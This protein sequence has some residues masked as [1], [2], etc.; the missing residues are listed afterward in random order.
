M[1]S[2]EVRT[3]FHPRAVPVARQKQQVKTHTTADTA[4]R[5][6][7]L[8]TL[9]YSTGRTTARQRSAHMQASS[10]GQPTRLSMLNT[11]LVR[12]RGCFGV[13]TQR[14]S[15]RRMTDIRSTWEADSD[16]LSL[17]NSQS[18]ATLATPPVTRMKASMASHMVSHRA[19][20][21]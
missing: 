10:R 7:H 5:Y 20:P 21:H 2:C 14:A 11:S 3:E 15:G 1:L 12:S 13:V 6:S 9:R 8:L 18:R 16:F 4:I 17:R 19:S